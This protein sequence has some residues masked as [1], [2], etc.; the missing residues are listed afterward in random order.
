[1]ASRN[2]GAE[3]RTGKAAYPPLAVRTAQLLSGDLTIEEL[4]DEEIL[5][6]QLR[7]ADGSFSGN[8]RDMVPRKLA[9]AFR[10][11]LIRR[12]EDRIAAH[13]IEAIETV[14]DVMRHGEGAQLSI[15]ER[16][17]SNR[18]KAAG[19][20]L[21]RIMGKPEQKTVVSGEV[22]IWQQAIE[23]GSLL[24]DVENPAVV[25][26]EVVAELPAAPSR[27]PVRRRSTRARK[28]GQES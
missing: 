9:D 19:M 28:Q 11:E 5:R 20:I 24:V 1:M 2:Q 23:D 26:A 27:A 21:D 6:G 8:R 25:E 22:T 7:S 18:L 15:H 13:G 14:V 4:D 16:E 17:G 12:M 3:V 10:R